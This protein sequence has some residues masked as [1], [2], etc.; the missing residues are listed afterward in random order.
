MYDWAGTERARRA[1]PPGEGTDDTATPDA[2]TVTATCWVAVEGLDGSG[3][4]TLVESLAARLGAEVVRNPPAGWE[5]QRQAA[6]SAP[7][8]SRRDGYLE[9]NRAAEAAALEVLASGTSVVM[10][11]SVAGTLAFG[12]AELGTTAAASD[13]STSIPRPD[14]IVFLDLPE[15]TRRNRLHGRAGDQTS[16]EARLATDQEFRR[17][18]ID[19]YR[20]LGAV[21]VDAS[22]SPEEVTHRVLALL[23]THAES[24]K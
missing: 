18:V 8:A 20:S 11:R 10:D 12:A 14:L 4:S 23:R 1:G 24:V 15:P 9:A 3:K 6:D 7:A 13:W 19:G 21:S 5:R 2:P 16:E 22:G 17:K